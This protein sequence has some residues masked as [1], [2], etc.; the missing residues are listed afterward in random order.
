MLRAVTIVAVRQQHHETILGV[1][2]DFTSSNELIDHDLGAISEVTELSFPK[3]ESVGISR[4]V[5]VFVTENGILRQMRAR[6][7]EP[8]G[9][10]QFASDIVDWHSVTIFILVENMSVSV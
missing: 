8:S 10:I 6:G 7:D 5:T 1:P 2:L 9:A 3:H 4:S